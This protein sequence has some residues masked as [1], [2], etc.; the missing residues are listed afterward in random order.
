[1]RYLMILAALVATV[2]GA[3]WFSGF[4]AKDDCLDSGGQYIDGTCEH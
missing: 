3:T 2:L 1:M 4:M